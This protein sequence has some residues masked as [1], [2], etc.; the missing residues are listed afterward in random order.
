MGTAGVAQKPL[1]WSPSLVVLLLAAVGLYEVFEAFL[2]VLAGDAHA[3][4]GLY[5]V[6]HLNAAVLDGESAQ[7][8][9]SSM[10]AQAFSLLSP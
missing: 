9:A 8:P 3:G 10:A 2:G 5:R 7:Y 1:Y 6:A 4:E